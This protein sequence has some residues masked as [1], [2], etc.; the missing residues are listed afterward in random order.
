[1]AF[2]VSVW[3]L[4]RVFLLGLLVSAAPTQHQCTE[5][6]MMV[7]KEWYDKQDLKIFEVL[8]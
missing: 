1:M 5:K 7:R 6:N 2:R 4:V 3:T 8:V